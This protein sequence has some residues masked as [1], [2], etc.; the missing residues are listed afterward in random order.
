MEHAY[1]AIERKFHHLLLMKE[2][3]MLSRSSS[4]WDLVS[5]IENEMK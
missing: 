2:S 1:E 3:W 4:A 5:S